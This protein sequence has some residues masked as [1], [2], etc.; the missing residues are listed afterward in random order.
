[1]EHDERGGFR[2]RKEGK[3]KRKKKDEEKNKN[4]KKKKKRRKKR[5][6]KMEGGRKKNG[7]TDNLGIKSPNIP[8][9]GPETRQP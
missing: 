5:K 6:K 3:R 2:K 4:K 1:M 7:L 9:D 8:T